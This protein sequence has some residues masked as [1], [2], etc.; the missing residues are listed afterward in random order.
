MVVNI[1]GGNM[2]MV[3]A[4]SS[5]QNC[6]MWRQPYPNAFAGYGTYGGQEFS[7]QGFPNHPVATEDS[8]V[9]HQGASTSNTWAG[10]QTGATTSPPSVNINV[11]VRPGSTGLENDWN[12]LTNPVTT[13]NTPQT[14]SYGGYRQAAVGQMPAM[15]YPSSASNGQVGEGTPPMQMCGSPE[16]GDG[17]PGSQGG[18]MNPGVTSNRQSQRAPYDWMKKVPYPTV[19][20]SGKSKLI[21]LLSFKSVFPFSK[22]SRVY[23]G[24]QNKWQIMIK[25]S[26]AKTV[27]K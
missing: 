17:S 11:N 21:L 13:A 16:L 14:T 2:Q 4:E 15:D 1:T 12:F 18:G 23:F 27:S 3:Q 24:D 20:S 9:Q 25:I 22:R 10:Y 26:F 6:A 8:R 5:Y 19:P 7:P